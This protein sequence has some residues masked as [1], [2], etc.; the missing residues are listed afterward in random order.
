MVDYAHG[1]EPIPAPQTQL[2]DLPSGFDWF[3]ARL[4]RAIGWIAH[5][6]VIVPLAL[7][8]IAAALAAITNALQP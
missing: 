4:V 2:E 8:G 1:R 6:W 7:I 5:N 3:L